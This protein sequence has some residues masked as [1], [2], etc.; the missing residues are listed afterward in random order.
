[1]YIDVYFLINLVVDRCA[2]EC[3][4]GCLGVSKRKLWLGAVA[5]A[6]GACLWKIWITP[7]MLQ[8]FGALLLA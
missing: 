1:M 8:P 4:I 3:A 6:A 7:V 2:L 5:G